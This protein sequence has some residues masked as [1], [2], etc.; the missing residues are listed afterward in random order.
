MS[1][2]IPQEGRDAVRSM[3]RARFVIA[4]G[5]VMIA[6]AFLAS[7]SI[8]P[9]YLALHAVAPPANAQPPSVSGESDRAKIGRTQVLLSALGPL[10]AATTS[11]TQAISLALGLRGGGVRIDHIT[12][13]SGDPDVITISGSAETPAKI[14]AYRKGLAAQAIFKNVS[15][16]VGD[17]VGA[18]GGRFSMTLQGNF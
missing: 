4:G 10:V 2:V 14:D 16:P 18:Q 11:P 9:S 12:F 5:L 3:Y 15:V 7:L 6:T 17:L 8:L 1:N 13:T